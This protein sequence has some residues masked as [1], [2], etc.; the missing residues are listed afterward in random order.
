MKKY[1]QHALGITSLFFAILLFA[2]TKEKSTS[3]ASQ[4]TSVSSEDALL[5]GETSADTLAFGTYTIIKFIDSS[6]DHTSQFTGYTFKFS[7]NKVLTVKK[8]GHQFTGEWRMNRD[9]T[10][11]VIDI[12]GNA[13]LN[14]LDG[15]W[16]VA[17]LTDVRLSLVRKGPDK[18]VFRKEP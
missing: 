5:P 11:M 6:V 15:L 2:C 8:G 17:R 9:D 4:Q 10:K 3:P 13:S 7:A 14:D 18:V 1:P 16:N 12:S